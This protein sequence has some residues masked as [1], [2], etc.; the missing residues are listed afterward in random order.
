VNEI[1]DWILGVVQSVEP[2]LR[3]LLSGVAMFCE[4]SVLLGLVVPGDTIVL[5]SSTAT[6]GPGEYAA[7]LVAVVVGS[8]LGESVGFALGR[9]FGPRIRRS[10][11]GRR[12][13]EHNWARAERYLTRRGGMAV[14]V[15]RFLPVLHSLIPLTVGMSTM[16]YRR[17]LRWTVPACLIWAAGYVTVGWL[18][19]DSYR[20]LAGELKWA[21]W[22][23][24]AILVVFWVAVILIKRAVERAEARHMHEDAE[25]AGDA[26]TADDAAEPP[27][28]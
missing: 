22:V 6:N 10:A 4:T 16:P 26:L 21:G 13:G 2:W 28:E 14:F 15:S 12:L 1:L 5:V 19:A 24:A 17:F 11:L 27:A 23:F 3:I 9:F 25:P 7:L 8:L 18:A 20:R